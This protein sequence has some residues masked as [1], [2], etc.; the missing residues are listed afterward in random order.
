VS[1][2]DQHLHTLWAALDSDQFAALR[3]DTGAHVS[4]SSP[5]LAVDASVANQEAIGVKGDGLLFTQSEGASI[6]NAEGA[7]EDSH[8][9]GFKNV[10][11]TL[12]AHHGLSTWTW[13]AEF[14]VIA[15]AASVA[16]VQDEDDAAVWRF[17]ASV[18]H[19]RPGEAWDEGMAPMALVWATYEVEGTL[20]IAVAAF[21]P[22][23]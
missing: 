20:H 22:M 5:P 18:I 21:A 9:L 10:G 13:P 2:D 12:V 15:G 14:P 8:D 4:I 19:D 23:P 3:D 17:A 11:V 16:A 7:L 1:P 6:W